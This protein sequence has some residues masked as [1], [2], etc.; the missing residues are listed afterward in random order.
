MKI[1]HDKNGI[2]V[3]LV[4]S[5][6]Q[7]ELKT[8]KQLLYREAVDGVLISLHYIKS[9]L[10]EDTCLLGGVNALSRLFSPKYVFKGIFNLIRAFS[11]WCST[12]QINNPLPMQVLPPLI[13]T[14][15]F[16]PHSRL[17][18]DLIVMAPKKHCSFMQNNRW[19][20]CYILT[21]K[22]CSQIF[23]GCSR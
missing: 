20:Y 14:R 11:A 12:C 15:S 2:L 13:P 9:V 19:S 5:Y 8:T 10:G 16:S 7:G 22:C 3:V 6:V 17:Q 18:C 21:V 23:V 4:N 1:V